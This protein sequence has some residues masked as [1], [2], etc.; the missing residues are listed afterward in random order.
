MSLNIQTHSVVIPQNNMSFKARGKGLSKLFVNPVQ[1]EYVE[2]VMKDSHIS[3]IKKQTVLQAQ[4]YNTTSNFKDLFTDII[5]NL[6][7]IL[8]KNTS[9]LKPIIPNHL[10]GGVTT[11]QL[12]DYVLHLKLKGTDKKTIDFVIAHLLESG[13]KDILKGAEKEIIQKIKTMPIGTIEE[14]DEFLKYSKSVK[15]TPKI[16]KTLMERM[17]IITKACR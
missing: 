16:H 2:N 8:F 11:E 13:K 4:A 10:E 7:L 15:L 9:K 5:T 12:Y 1:R 17:D 14:L 6:K 3:D